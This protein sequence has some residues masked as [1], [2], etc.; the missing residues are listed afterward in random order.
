M[1]LGSFPT[2]V[3][4]L[5]IELGGCDLWVKRE[6]L[7]GERYGGNKVR[8]LEYLLGE[9][10]GRPLLTIGASGSHHILAT[11]LYGREADCPVYGVMAPQ[12]DSPHVQANRALMESLLA[13]WQD[14][15]SR[16]LIPWGMVQ[17]RLRLRRDELPPPVNIPAGGSNPTGSLGW[18]AGGLEIAEQVRDGLLPIPD[19]IWLPL[20]SGGNAAGLLVGLRLAGLGT[21]IMAVRVVEYPLTSGIATL[22]L[23]QRTVGLLR[24]LGVT[25]PPG[26]HTS[27]LEVVNGYIGRGYGHDTAAAAQAVR[28]ASSELGLT[29]EPTYTAKTLAACVE[30]LQRGQSVGTALFLDTVS[31]R[32]LPAP[33]APW[34]T[35]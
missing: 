12:P 26:F 34:P 13:G 16:L 8:K 10:R 19:Q 17:L 5:P 30:R 25:I 4:R 14:V 32:P 23:A 33:G 22:H 29:L 27:G 18:V 28:M 35:P 1:D 20:G 6:D 31:S 3:E 15:P 11:A 2:P 21:R 7:S 24:S 9:H